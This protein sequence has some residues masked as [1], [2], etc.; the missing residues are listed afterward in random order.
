MVQGAFLL[1]LRQLGDIRRDPRRLILREQLGRGIARQKTVNA[2]DLTAAKL[3]PAQIA[4]AQKFTR[5][6]KPKPER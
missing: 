2:R 6:W 1:L 4:E 3:T 5:E